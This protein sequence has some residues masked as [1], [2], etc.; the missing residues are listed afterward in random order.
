SRAC[1]ALPTHSM[2]RR[3]PRASRASSRSRRLSSTKST[4]AGRPPS[5][6]PLIRRFL[7]RLQGIGRTSCR[8]ESRAWG[9]RF[10]PTPTAED[11]EPVDPPLGAGGSMHRAEELR[12]SQGIA[13]EL[14]AYRRQVDAFRWEVPDAFNFGRDVVDRRALEADGPAL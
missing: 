14:D 2:R 4:R 7:E 6:S 13:R 1:S 9:I 10:G 12:M 3:S 5:A 8:L 11:Q